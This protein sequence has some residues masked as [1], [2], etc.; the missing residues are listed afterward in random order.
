VPQRTGWD[1]DYNRAL[2]RIAEEAGFDYAL[3]PATELRVMA[4]HPG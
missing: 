4:G 1:A 3:T 2:A